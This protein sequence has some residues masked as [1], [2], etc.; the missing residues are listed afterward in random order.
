MSVLNST[1]PRELRKFVQSPRRLAAVRVA[2]APPQLGLSEQELLPRRGRGHVRRHS[3]HGGDVLD[4]IAEAGVDERELLVDELE[5]AHFAVRGRRLAQDVSDGLVVRLDEEDGRLGPIKGETD[6][7]ARNFLIFQLERDQS[8]KVV[9]RPSGTE[10]KAKAYLEV[11]SAPCRAGITT[12]AW[13]ASCKAIDDL[14]QRIASDFLK[15]ALA[16]VGQTPTPGSDRL[17]E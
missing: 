10:P 11:C 7:A 12:Q 15:Q 16:T 17:R 13:E 14:A 2:I 9:L 3:C 5:L 8:A 6:F 4:E 1:M